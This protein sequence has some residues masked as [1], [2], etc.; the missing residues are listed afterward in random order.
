[1][2]NI[3]IGETIKT[4]TGITYVASDNT[5]VSVMASKEVIL[6]VSLYYHSLKLLQ[7]SGVGPTDLFTAEGIDV[8]VDL[9]VGQDALSLSI[10]S[11][12]GGYLNPLEPATNSTV[13]N[14]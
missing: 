4:A 11:V 10:S 14:S 13:I 3:L 2:T 8:V 9:P 6:P 12:I 7:L 1:V 5:G